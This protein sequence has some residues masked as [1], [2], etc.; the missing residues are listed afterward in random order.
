MMITEALQIYSRLQDKILQLPMN[1]LLLSDDDQTH[2]RSQRMDKM[3]LD[4]T[5]H[6]PAHLR[7]RVRAEFHALGPLESLLSDEGI[8]EIL[9]NGPKSI[10]FEKQ[11]QLFQHLDSFFSELSFRNAV[12]RLCQRA[13][14][15]VTVAHPSVDAQWGDFRLSLVS[16]EITKNSMHFSLRRHPKNPWNFKKLLEV[17]WCRPEDFCLFEKIM[18]ERKNFLIVGT[19]GSGKTSILNSCLSLLP[20]NERVVA[21]EDTPEISL[22]NKAS[23]KLLTRQDP[24]GLLPE[25]DQAQLVKRS[26]RLRPD[27]IVMGEVRGVEAKDFLMALATGH[28]SLWKFWHSSREFR[29]PSF[30]SLGD[31]N[32]DGGSAMEFVGHP[33]SDSTLARLHSGHR[34]RDLRPKILKWSL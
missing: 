12:D 21:I 7:D 11:G 13:H 2:L 23:M 18:K 15:H 22:A 6:L 32:T 8:T 24:Q 33:S 26:L 16:N 3:I 28:W 19:T 17:G 9:V 1:E 5:D 14:T 34:A 31:V 27:R 20:E 4:E 29:Q 10:W 30:D 25:I